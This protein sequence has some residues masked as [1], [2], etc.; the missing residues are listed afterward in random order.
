MS[1][2]ELPPPPCTECEGIHMPNG[3]GW[4]DEWSEPGDP[5]EIGVDCSG[6]TK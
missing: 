4:V 6:V 1:G 3:S 5:G 2:M